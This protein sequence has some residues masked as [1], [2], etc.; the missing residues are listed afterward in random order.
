MK[1][2]HKFY[3]AGSLLILLALS[4]VAIVSNRHQR[5]TVIQAGPA[6]VLAQPSKP[7]KQTPVVSVKT[8]I[9]HVTG[10]PTRR[11]LSLT[12]RPDLGGTLP[13]PP[14]QEVPRQAD[15]TYIPHQSIF[16]TNYLR[17]QVF[18]IDASRDTMLTGDAGTR[19]RVPAQAFVTAGGQAV[20]GRVTLQLKEAYSPAD[21]ALAGLFT[22]KGKQLLES[23]GMYYLNAIHDKQNLSVAPGK[24]LVLSIPTPV[25]AENMELYEGL[26][27][28]SGL[29]WAS[30]VALNPGPQQAPLVADAQAQNAKAENLQGDRPFRREAGGRRI[31]VKR[32][33]RRVVVKDSLGWLNEGDHMVKEDFKNTPSGHNGFYEDQKLRYLM[34]TNRMGWANIDRLYADKRCRQVEF[35]TEVKNNAGYDYVYISMLFKSQ[36]IYLPGYQKADSTYSFTH[37][38][39]EQ[40]VLP[41]G[42]TALVMVSAYKNKKQYFAME[43]ITITSRINLVLEP[44]AATDE[45]IKAIV[46][47]SL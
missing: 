7:I 23:G 11:R 43:Q 9:T 5:S 3:I 12:A 25:V 38:D 37:G 1:R 42:E 24:Q 4:L 44:V 40:P 28:V 20:T 21:I 36:R 26:P 33:G 17:M 6:P 16:S 29:D 22:K 34:Q 2:Q 47:K 10:K 32:E 45:E 14:L 41:V 18:Q 30:P 13:S 19:I 27:T 39:Y 31:K 8:Q 46:T 35:V 15:L